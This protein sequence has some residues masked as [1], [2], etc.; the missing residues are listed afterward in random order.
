M[1][2]CQRS[3]VRRAGLRFALREIAPL[4]QH[5]RLAIAADARALSFLWR[6]CRFR[7]RGIVN[8]ASHGR[9]GCGLH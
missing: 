2:A 8:T 4:S 5:T 9:Q 1:A 3:R 7:Q 6:S